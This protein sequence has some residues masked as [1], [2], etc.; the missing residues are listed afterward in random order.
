MSTKRGRKKAAAKPA[1]PVLPDQEPE[2]SP[3]ELQATAKPAAPPSPIVTLAKHAITPVVAA[4]KR[5]VSVIAAALP[6]IPEASAVDAGGLDFDKQHHP[7]SPR[8]PT[9]QTNPFSERQTVLRDAFSLQEDDAA[10]GSDQQQLRQ[11]MHSSGSLQRDELDEE[12]EPLKE[13][14]KQQQASAAAP[15]GV[16]LL[17]HAL[18]LWR[19]LS[20]WFGA[21]RSSG[22]LP[23]LALGMLLLAGMLGMLFLQGSALREQQSMIS[24][25][26]QQVAAQQT[27]LAALQ[28]QLQQAQ[29]QLQGLPDMQQ[30]QHD[31]SSCK[32]GLDGLGSSQDSL[33]ETLDF[34]A[35]LA[36][37]LEHNV[38]SLS[39]ASTL[40]EK[41]WQLFGA[42]TGSNGAAMTADAAAA[43]VAAP[44]LLQQ[45]QQQQELAQQLQQSMAV[46]DTLPATIK[47]EVQQQLSAAL[48]PVD[49]ALADCGARIAFHTPLNS[50]AL[51]AAAAG[52]STAVSAAAPSGAM[53][54]LQQQ[55]AQRLLPGGMAAA[56][57]Q[58]GQLLGAAQ[59]N[60]IILRPQRAF[61]ASPALAGNSAAA[62][63]DPSQGSISCLP[64]LLAPAGGSAAAA[65]VL[66]IAL[67]QP[68]A[69]ESVTFHHTTS[70]A[71]QHG[72]YGAAPGMVH[73][74]LANS[75]SCPAG[76]CSAVGH[77]AVMNINASA[78][79][80][81][82]AVDAAASGDDAQ[83]VL[84]RGVLGV[85]QEVTLCPE[86]FA[87]GRAVVKIQ[88]AATAAADGESSAGGG[89][90]GVV[91]DRLIVHVSSSMGG[92]GG[93][94]MQ[95]I[96]VQGMP[97]DP[98]SFC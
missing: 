37:Q 90:A 39:Q 3:A 33:Q 94:C 16:R 26:Q 73:I 95:R 55:V 97:V 41:A 4:A 5:A 67:P 82:D 84:A 13:E 10:Q 2:V 46:L 48:P 76:L 72:S 1:G 19:N 89:R 8:S 22:A 68:A 17:Q 45:T 42:A 24:Q 34:L 98:A 58:Q 85:Q 91:A 12:L 49:L 57:Q 93:L 15:L 60:S 79:D 7:D 18:L 31:A 77:A 28:E 92:G 87:G 50:T 35:A 75:S 65:A 23:V 71:E 30:L 36:G 40:G 78:A 69:I 63:A 29:Q 52:A 70:S 27:A 25:Q 96:S 54:W 83:S 38:S 74:A 62:A 88:P 81:V 44:A 53:Q 21:Q 80:A 9:G 64:L 61:P 6:A 66:E 51:A 59:I 86:S 56:R 11:G 47:S 43:A 20:A 14:Q 32:T